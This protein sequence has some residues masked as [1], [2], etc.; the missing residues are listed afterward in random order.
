M[1]ERALEV[2]KWILY[3]V[4]GMPKNEI[5]ELDFNNDWMEIEPIREIIEDGKKFDEV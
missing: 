5:K 3:R 2:Y 1:E 4:N